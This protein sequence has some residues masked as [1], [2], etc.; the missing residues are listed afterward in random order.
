MKTKQSLALICGAVMLAGCAIPPSGENDLYYGFTLVDPEAR[1]QTP[2]SWLVVRDG[3]IARV[4]NGAPPAGDYRQRH[5]MTGRYGMPGLIDAHAHLV[6]GPYLIKAANGGVSIDIAA[7]D[8]YTRFNAAIALAFGVTTLR[9]P[10]GSTDAAARYDAMR[11]SGDWIGPQALHAGR[12]IEPPPLSGQSIAYPKTRMEWDAE[13]A[14]QAAAGMTYFKLYRGLTVAELEEGVRAA[15]AH[16]L[17]PIAHSEAVSWT[18]AAELG[19]RQIEHTLPISPDLLPPDRRTQYK[20]DAP[21]SY[22]YFQW[23]Q[24]AE[25]DGPLV[26]GMV[27]TLREKDVV[28]TPTLMAQDVIS[29]ADDLS[30]VF[31]SGDLQYY[32]PESFASAKSNYDAIAKVWKPQDFTSARATWPT[33]LRFVKLLHESGIKLMIGTDGTGGAPVYARELRNMAQTGISHWEILRMATSGN[34]ELMGL[35]NT[36]RIAEGKEADLVFLRADPV[37]DVGNVQQVEMVVSDGKAYK[38]NE[39][40]ALSAPFAK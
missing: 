8:K 1:T 24:L 37:A 18:R 10:G 4:G 9:N 26:R 30:P 34:A 36:G 13:A 3:K 17:I 5:D 12:V 40:I 14:R 29:H 33:I 38:F 28:V 27:R 11:A 16:G 35:A 7:A 20:P 32:Q 15:R 23:F 31:P 6:A 2:A 39:L 19:I 21:P 25:L 22:G